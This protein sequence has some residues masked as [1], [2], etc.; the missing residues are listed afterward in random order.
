MRIKGIGVYSARRYAFAEILVM[1][2]KYC[3]G[4]LVLSDG[5]KKAAVWNVE[6]GTKVG[7]PHDEDLFE[8]LRPA[9]PR[10]KKFGE[11]RT[12]PARLTEGVPEVPWTC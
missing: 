4:Y 6:D 10:D 12:S 7:G 8:F 11:G 3:L 1:R 2:G 9:K 5:V